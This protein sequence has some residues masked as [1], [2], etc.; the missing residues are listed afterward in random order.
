M[1]AVWDSRFDLGFYLPPKHEAT[2][3]YGGSTGFGAEKPG[4]LP[5]HASKEERLYPSGR[6][7]HA[8]S[9]CAMVH[10]VGEAECVSWVT[11]ESIGTFLF[12]KQLL[13]QLVIDKKIH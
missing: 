12:Q 4:L 1:E 11:R 3:G 8:R 6:S 13:P 7:M 10:M 5:G 9:L 2:C